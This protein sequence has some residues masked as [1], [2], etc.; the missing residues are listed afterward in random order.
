MRQL[1][2]WYDV[3]VIYEEPVSQHYNGTVYRQVNA[4]KVLEMLEKAGG[5]KFSIVGRKVI[6]SK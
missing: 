3:D 2:R 6:V 1:S 4:S 5:V